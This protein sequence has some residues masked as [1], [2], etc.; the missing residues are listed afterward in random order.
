M[1]ASKRFSAALTLSILFNS[2]SQN[3][4]FESPSRIQVPLHLI[5]FIRRSIGMSSQLVF[6]HVACKRTP[7]EASRWSIVTSFAKLRARLDGLIWTGLTIE[8]VRPPG[9]VA[10]SP[11]THVLLEAVAQTETEAREAD[12]GWRASQASHPTCAKSQRAMAYGTA[13]DREGPLPAAGPWRTHC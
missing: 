7:V 13:F 1:E 5:R 9:S 12:C 8:T 3:N 4:Q 2:Q 6:L 11:L 10:A